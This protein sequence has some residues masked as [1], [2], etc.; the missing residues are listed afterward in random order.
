MKLPNAGPEKMGLLKAQAWGP[1]P[2][3]E[4]TGVDHVATQVRNHHWINFSSQTSAV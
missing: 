2:Q 4:A 3:G 1:T